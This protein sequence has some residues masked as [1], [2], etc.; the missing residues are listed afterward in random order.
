MG[1]LQDAAQYMRRAADII[2][3]SSLP[4]DNPYRVNYPSWADQFEKEANMQQDM[5]EQMWKWGTGFH[6]IHPR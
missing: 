2:S 5:M 6:G 3:K 4:E 1:Q